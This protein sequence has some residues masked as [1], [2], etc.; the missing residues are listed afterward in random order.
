MG[1][2]SDGV[3]KD[4]LGVWLHRLVYWPPNKVG[5]NAACLLG[6]VSRAVGL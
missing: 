1:G 5:L 4:R 3:S 6:T 2:M